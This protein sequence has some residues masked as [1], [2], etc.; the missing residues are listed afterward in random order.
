MRL[1]PEATFDTLFVAQRLQIG[2]ATF[3]APQL[4]LVGYLACLLS[5]YRRQPVTD[6]GYPFIGTE[7]GAPFSPEIDTAVK[8][9][10]ERGFLSGSRERLQMTGVAE[11]QLAEL[12][13]LA[14]NQER[15]ECLQAACAST[16]VFSI[17]M[18]GSALSQ[19][20]ELRRAQALPA[21]RLLLEESAQVQLYTQ[22]DAL[23]QAL[24]QRTNDLRLPAVVW[25]NALYRS[26]EP[27]AV[28][29]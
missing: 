4:H 27:S 28:V 7:L 19:E 22:F 6:W 14:L 25:L 17:G 2:C 8:E 29:Q 10:T 1:N 3:S 20:P 21:T 9:L 24:S 16:S 12:R 5:L 18:V 13:Q 26:S 15:A 23:R 11:K